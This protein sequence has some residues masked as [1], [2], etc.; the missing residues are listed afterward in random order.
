VDEGSGELTARKVDPEARARMLEA[1]AETLRRRLDELLD[2]L[3][4]RR[5]RAA[6]GLALLRRYGVPALVAVAMMSGGV[7]AVTRWRRRRAPW[8][9]VA[10]RLPASR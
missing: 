6:G 5:R 1:E 10:L 2:E 9:R 7:Y 4:R 8:Y 3:D